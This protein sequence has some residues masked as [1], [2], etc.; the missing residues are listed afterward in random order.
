MWGKFKLAAVRFFFTLI[1]LAKQLPL[2][3]KDRSI[4][5]ELP[6]HRLE[7]PGT[8]SSETE[9]QVQQQQPDNNDHDRRIQ[10]GNVMNMQ[11]ALLVIGTCFAAISVVLQALQ[12]RATLPAASTFPWLCVAF[13]MAFLAMLVS[14]YIRRHHPRSSRVMEH[15]AVFFCAVS[16]LLAIRMT[17]DPPLK[18]M[19][20]ALFFIGF[21]I[22]I[23]ANRSLRDWV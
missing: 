23:L 12:I 8:V 13:E 10:I 4:P 15:V 9:E 21:T 2:W 14:I 1:G 17:L 3:R 20:V 7:L 11:W 19:S 6:T 5:S 18:Q 16:L 22:I